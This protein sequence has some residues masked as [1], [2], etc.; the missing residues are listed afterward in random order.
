MP[1]TFDDRRLLPPGIHDATLDDVERHFSLSS[2]RKRL[3]EN[4]KQ[5][6]WTVRLTGWACQVIVDGSF[7]M[8][9]VSEPNDVD[10]LVVMPEG[11]DRARK[12][13]K[14][15]EYGVV[16]RKT[17]KSELRVEIYTASPGSAKEREFIELYTNIRPEWCQ[18]FGW[19]VGSRKGIVRVE[20]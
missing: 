15:S 17:V 10:V 12:D 8:P 2:R 20:L 7:V 6:L 1:L 18:K 3:F 4:L 11:W 16:D 5:Y 13:L 9:M 14:A 19:P